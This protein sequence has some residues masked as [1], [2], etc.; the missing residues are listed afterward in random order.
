M[1]P[2][3]RDTN[4]KSTFYKYRSLTQSTSHG[5][6]LD[7]FELAFVVCIHPN[8]SDSTTTDG[9]YRWIEWQINLDLEEEVKSGETT[10]KT[11]IPSLNMKHHHSMVP[12]ECRNS[13]LS[14][15]FLSG[16]L[17]LGVAVWDFLGFVI[18]ACLVLV[19]IISHLFWVQSPFGQWNAWSLSL[20]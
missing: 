16:C 19:V 10:S 1:L 9:V 15:V 20:Q 14:H 7:I 13:G 6:S 8:L 17:T 12:M 4:I 2:T 5:K 11:W 18:P 3:S